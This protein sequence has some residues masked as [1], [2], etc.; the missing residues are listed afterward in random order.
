MD[1]R[2]TLAFH[3]GS[4]AVFLSTPARAH[5]LLSTPA[6]AHFFLST[7]ARSPHWLS[8]LAGAQSWLQRP[9]IGLRVVSKTPKTFEFHGFPATCC[10][11]VM[12]SHSY[13]YMEYAL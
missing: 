6:R 1:P 9:T 8:T 13:C 5:F 2:A 12:A 3:T 11:I 4:L 7:L 10:K